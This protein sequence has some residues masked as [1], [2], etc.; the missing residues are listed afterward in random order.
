MLYVAAA[1]GAAA[2]RAAA[3]RAAA[4][5]AAAA[6][7]GGDEAGGGAAGDNVGG[8]GAVGGGGGS[9]RCPAGHP[10]RRRSGEDAGLR[11]DGGCGRLL[12][13]GAAGWCCD[14]GKI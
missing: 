11:C 14:Q 6:A 7:A 4:A 1:E 12:R 2:A 9:G 5:R 10:L 3:A 13:R 8:G